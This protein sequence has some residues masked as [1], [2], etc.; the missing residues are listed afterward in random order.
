MRLGGLALRDH[1]FEVPLDHSAPGGETIRIFGREVAA[2]GK[3]DDTSLPW[4][5][6]LQG[7]PGGKGP[8]PANASGWLG[9]A[10]QDFRVL[11]LD[12]RGTGRSAPVT[13]RTILRHGDAA[14]QASYLGHFRADSIVADA[15]LIRTR[16]LGADGK[17]S[18]LGQSF[19][20]FCTLTYLSFA[21][22]G[23]AAA[24]I[25]GG[26]APILAAA[27][28]VYQ[29]TYQHVRAKNSA[30]HAAFP[31]ARAKLEAVAEHLRSHDVRLPDG[32][33]LSVRRMQSAGDALGSR[34][35]APSLQY[36][37]EE[38]FVDGPDGREL[39]DTFLADVHGMLSF[40]GRPLFAAL[41]EPIYAQGSAPRWAA[42]RLRPADFAP[43]AVP[44]LL[45]GEMIYPWMFDDDPAL[46]PFRD[47]AHVLAERADWPPLYDPRVLASNEVPAAAALYLDD[48]YV[49]AD[50]SAQTAEA[51]RGLRVWKTNA[52]EHDGL[53]ESEDVLDRLIRMARGEI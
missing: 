1:W 49:D 10:V 34:G 46:R 21:P 28:D 42:E 20:G 53:R 2:A 22:G 39:S 3:A 51:V 25:T 27:D 15:E 4:L 52:F 47:A 45:T 8:R 36:L 5:L 9:R 40:A 11:L 41:H 13:S 24:Y 6:F 35:R 29:R 37:L 23:L 14:G 18:V 17:W 19:G 43:D 32:S 44:L 7:G 48:M 50:L 12:Q 31:E 33:P 26:L 38:A 16:L 30:F